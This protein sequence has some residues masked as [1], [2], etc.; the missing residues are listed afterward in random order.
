MKIATHIL[1][2]NQ[3]K[4]ILKQIE[5]IAPFV[6]KIYVAWSKFP[7]SYNPDARNLFLN[8][9]NPEMLKESDYYHKIE[10]IIG[11]WKLDEEQRNACLDAAKR[12]DMDYLLIIDADEFYS[13][14]DLVKL[15]NNINKNPD[16]EYYKTPWVTYWKNFNNIIVDFNDNYINGFPEVCVNLK[17]NNRFVRCR[18]PSGENVLTLDSL[19]KHASYVLSDEECWSKINTW[20]HAHQFDKELWFNSK[21]L[22][23]NK[24]VTNLH[25]ISPSD[26]KMAIETPENLKFYE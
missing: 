24:S 10:L 14:D 21:W 6:D 8:K 16:Y 4:W 22:N 20:G 1:L 7:W 19:C 5:M 18:R 23:W 11:D 25:P 17:Y 15:I 13:Y 26:W 12:D 2:F 9:S 3:D